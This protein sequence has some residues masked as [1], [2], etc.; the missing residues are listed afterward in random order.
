MDL[1]WLKFV[2]KSNSFKVILKKYFE[3]FKRGIHV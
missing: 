3:I 1:M 2:V